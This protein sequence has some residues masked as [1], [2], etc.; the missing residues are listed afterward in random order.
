MLAIAAVA[1]IATAG[2]FGLF[3]PTETRYAEIAREMRAGGDY[4][5][6]HLNGI[7]HF[8]KPPFAY[9]AAA[10][11]MTMFGENSW[12]ARI[13]VA[14]ASICALAFA[15]MAARRRFLGLG[16]PPAIVIGLL[17]TM[18]LPFAL[19]RT[20]AADP[21]LAAAVAGFWAL[22]PSPTAIVMLGFGFFA[23]GPVVFVLTLLPV[24]VV[25]AWGRSRA[26]LR[27]L[28]PVWSW[29]LFA[30]IALPWFIMVALQV[31]E[32]AGFFVGHEL[33][34]RFATHAHR[35]EG[36]PW[37]F[38]A[39]IIGGAIPWTAAVVAGLARTWR[40]RTREEARLLLAW[41]LVPV[42][43]FSL[44]GSKLPAYVL[45]CFPA[46][47]MLAAL[48]LAQAGRVV[49]WMTAASLVLVAVAGAI[50][51]PAL[52]A[53]A[54]AAGAGPPAPLP[55][56]VSVALA[57]WAIA[58]VFVARA[59][60]SSAAIIVLAG[61][62]AVAFGL[63][64]YESP[65]G[66]PRAMVALLQQTRRP[67][68]PVV[69]IRKFNAGLLF[70]LREPVL[71]LGVERNLAFTPATELTHS[72]ITRDSL[73][74]LADRSDRVWLLAPGREGALLADSLGLE[75]QRLAVWRQLTLG[76][77]TRLRFRGGTPAR[78]GL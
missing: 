35:R 41:A 42:A 43:F 34:Q 29:G 68:E 40:E 16:G 44:S 69:E 67:G 47:A 24:L 3:E 22:A 5:V 65:L 54:V 23:K 72:I 70:Y 31:H 53:H 62:L 32:L 4:L 74:A 59:H 25:A 61:W 14:V 7:T 20:L 18:S 27:L 66:S 28:G 76:F 19:G 63:G 52:L 26:P 60:H 50:V 48:G 1:L 75:Y 36:P 46:F 39:V 78:P 45:P 73:V 17:A 15:W 57:L 38:I 10:R 30:A 13:P 51:G 21:F 11:G 71:L 9:W 2:A 77:A 56:L 64:R 33:W 12:G 6:P 37:Y 8:D 49:R 55:V 58:A